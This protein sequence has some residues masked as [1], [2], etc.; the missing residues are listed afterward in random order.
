[1]PEKICTKC[2]LVGQFHRAKHGKY[3][4]SSVCK[5]CVTSLARARLATPEGCASRMWS[6]VISRVG[7]H[8]NYLT[9]QLRMTRFEF[10][11]WAVPAL[12]EWLASRGALQPGQKKL[13]VSLDRRDSRGHY[14]IDNLQLR[15]LGQNSRTKPYNK[16]VFAADG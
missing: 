13:S 7:K 1:M 6:A 11:R 12:T 15:T 4:L 9:V 3:G 5:L 10:L 16:N 14:A 2:G 8:P